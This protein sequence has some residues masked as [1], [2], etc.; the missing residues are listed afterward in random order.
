MAKKSW[1]KDTLGMVVVILVIV[2]ALNWG[3]VGLLNFNLVNWLVGPWPLLEKL[4]YVL[5]GLAGVYKLYRVAR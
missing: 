2:G 3:L 4:V 1:D 5:V